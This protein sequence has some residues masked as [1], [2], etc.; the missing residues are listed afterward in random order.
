[1]REINRPTQKVPILVK[2]SQGNIPGLTSAKI[3]I[4]E[5]YFKKTLA[6]L[7]MENEFLDSPPC[8]MTT[9]F[10]AEEIK[11]IVKRLGNDKAA[12]PDKIQAEFL[13][14][15]P[16]SIHQDIANIFNITASTGDVPTALIHGLLCP[17]QKPGKKKGPPLKII[18][19]A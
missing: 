9:P 8:Q 12:G 11:S 18:L 16:K 1:M 4:I 7:H 5:E 3:K 2:D 15:A 10:T 14:Y 13:K 19:L 6:P 17:H